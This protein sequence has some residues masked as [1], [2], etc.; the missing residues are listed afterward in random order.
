MFIIIVAFTC[1]H[2]PAHYF[3]TML[4]N[5]TILLAIVLSVI[6]GIGAEQDLPFVVFKM[7]VTKPDD[8]LIGEYSLVW[9]RIQPT[10]VAHVETFTGDDVSIINKFVVKSSPNANTES[11]SLIAGGPGHTFV[12]LRFEYSRDNILSYTIELYGKKVTV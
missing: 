3:S 11:V 6:L 1:I 9:G 10:Q 5:H 12:T 4:S 8:Q 2:F 7:G